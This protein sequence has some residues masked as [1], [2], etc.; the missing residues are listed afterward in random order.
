MISLI[1][2]D[3]ICSALYPEALYV[4]QGIFEALISLLVLFL[5]KSVFYYVKRW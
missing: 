4:I 1:K 2:I 3:I 5:V